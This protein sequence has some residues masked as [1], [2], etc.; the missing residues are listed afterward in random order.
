MKEITTNLFG[1]EVGANSY[2]WLGGSALTEAGFKEGTP[3]YQGWEKGK[4]VFSIEPLITADKPDMKVNVRRVNTH[5]SG[6]VVRAEGRHVQETFDG[7]KSVKAT[8]SPGRIEFVGYERVELAAA[9]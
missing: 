3:Y 8:I 5:K 1:S 4:A 7:F 2:V 6:P 9:A